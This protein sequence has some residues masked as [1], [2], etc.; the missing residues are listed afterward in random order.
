[1]KRIIFLIVKIYTDFV[2]KPDFLH[3]NYLRIQRQEIKV[4]V[5]G[6]TKLGSRDDK[7]TIIVDF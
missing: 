7:Q 2:T 5:L 1:M 3:Q 4:F 6:V